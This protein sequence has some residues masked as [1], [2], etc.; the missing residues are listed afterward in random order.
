M[1]KIK[2]LILQ[3]VLLFVK[4]MGL[5]VCRKI[6]CHAVCV[7]ALLGFSLKANSIS[8]NTNGLYDISWYKTNTSEYTLTTAAQL[9]GLSYLVNNG[10]TNFSNKTV[11]L[12]NDIDVSPYEWYT[13]GIDYNTRFKGTFDGNKHTIRGLYILI[14][15]KNPQENIGLFGYIENASIKNV[16]INGDIDIMYDSY[17]NSVAHSGLLVGYA[18]RSKID[19]VFAKGNIINHRSE[20]NCYSYTNIIGGVVGYSSGGCTIQYCRF[21]GLLEFKTKSAIY[22][23]YKSL[24]ADI[25]GIVGH[26]SDS[27]GIIYF[28][29]VSNLKINFDAQSSSNSENEYIYIGGI[30]GY[31]SCLN[32]SIKCCASYNIEI[33]PWFMTYETDPFLYVGGIAGRASIINSI[34]N[35]YSTFM[36]SD[37]HAIGSGHRYLYEDGIVGSKSSTTEFEACYSP[38]DFNYTYRSGYGGKG[39]AG[40]QAYSSNQMKSDSFLTELNL[41]GQ[42]NDNKEYWGRD[43]EYPYLKELHEES[44]NDIKSIVNDKPQSK[45]IMYNLYGL[46]VKNE[47][48]GVVIKDGKKILVN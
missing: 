44:T 17:T 29:E 22:S 41:W 9:A 20:T 3:S 48:K 11:Y 30:V 45:S 36:G 5:I 6:I 18:V 26:C 27:N 31:F 4:P 10:F 43:N 34:Q 38:S 42:I 23:A 15:E 40:S 47:Y 7:F 13:I 8:W 46:P 19:H 21:E 28:C 14:N 39:Y 16:T 1:K 37:F 2:K 35:C 25:G 24:G 32:S 33:E 12:G